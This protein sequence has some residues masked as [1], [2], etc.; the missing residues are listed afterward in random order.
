MSEKQARYTL[1]LL[2]SIGDSI[3][4]VTRPLYPALVRGHAALNVARVLEGRY[5][6]AKIVTTLGKGRKNS[7]VILLCRRRGQT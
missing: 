5:L 1:A 2:S 4:D 6:A 7:A 3:A